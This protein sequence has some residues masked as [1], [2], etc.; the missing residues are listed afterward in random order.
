MDIGVA[1]QKSPADD[2]VGD[3]VVRYIP[4]GM[5][6]F[7]SLIAACGAD[8]K[9]GKLYCFKLNVVFLCILFSVTSCRSINSKNIAKL[10]RV[11]FY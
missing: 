3:F 5:N 6:Y 9:R 11:Y 1:I 4:S 2:S 7:I 10:E 8:S